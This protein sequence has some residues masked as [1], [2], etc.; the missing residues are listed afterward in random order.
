MSTYVNLNNIGGTVPSWTLTDRLRKARE[1]AGLDQRAFAERIGVSRSSIT[2]YETGHTHPRD[3]I[4]KLWALGTGVPLE[5]IKTGHSDEDN[6][7]PGGASE[8]GEQALLYKAAR[9]TGTATGLRQVM[10]PVRCGVA[11]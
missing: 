3:S 2:N 9:R 4:L 10:A 7:G 5:W 1:S 8:Q 6:G 11:A